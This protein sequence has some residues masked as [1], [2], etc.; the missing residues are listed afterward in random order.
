MELTRR[1]DSANDQKASQT[2]KAGP[3]FELDGTSFTEKE[4]MAVIVQGESL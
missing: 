3:F 2:K 4:L 1:G